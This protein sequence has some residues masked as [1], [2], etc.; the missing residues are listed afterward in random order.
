MNTYTD[1]RGQTYDLAALDREELALFHQLQ[2]DADKLDSAAYWN[3]ST[4]CVSQLLSAR[5]LSRTE[6]LRTPLYRLAQDLGSRQEVQ[7]GEART[8]D[9]RDDLEQII[10]EKFKTQRLPAC[11]VVVRPTLRLEAY[12]TSIQAAWNN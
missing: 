9:Y 5:G 11:G 4:A 10:R 2:T 6:M 3:H 8:P 1:L 12:A 7:R